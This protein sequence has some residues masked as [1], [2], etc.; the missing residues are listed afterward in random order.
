FW[1]HVRGTSARA[2]GVVLLPFVLG[3]VAMSI[4]SARLVLRVGYRALA[5]AG[6]TCLAVAF[7]LLT[8][9]APGL[10]QTVAMRDALLGGIGMGLTFVPMPLSVQ[11]P[12]AR[13]DLGA[14]TS[15]TQFLR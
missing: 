3:W 8:R 11:R 12:V 14:A 9:W 1:R 4:V 6:M 15:L 10:T 13:P 5:V 7:L 2:A